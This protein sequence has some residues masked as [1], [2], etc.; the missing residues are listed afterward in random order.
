[1]NTTKLNFRIDLILG[2]AFMLVLLSGLTARAAPE[3]MGLHAFIGLGL[4]FG[5]VIHLILHRKW[6][7]A[8]GR[9]SEKSG[10]LKP[11]LWL[12]RL[13]AVTWLW[14]LLSGLHGHLDPINGTPTH[15]LAAASMT[16]ILLIHLARH[17]KWVVTTTKRYWG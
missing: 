2:F 12:T 13:L 7:A 15:A 17:W 8:A 6:M 14:T 4:S 11:N 3:R 16:G 1:M 10:P 5:I 9:S